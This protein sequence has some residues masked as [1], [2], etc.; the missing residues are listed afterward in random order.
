MVFVPGHQLDSA[1]LINGITDTI[2]KLRKG[3]NCDLGDTNTMKR[4]V[5]Y[6]ASV[7]NYSES[8]QVNKQ[9]F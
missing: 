3:G 7:P 9:V 1:Y 5:L 8:I 4:I 2:L 6:L